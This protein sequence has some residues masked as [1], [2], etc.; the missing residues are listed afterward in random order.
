MKIV[1]IKKSINGEINKWHQGSPAVFIRFAGCNL[2]THPCKF[3]DTEYSLDSTAGKD[4]SIYELKDVLEQYN[5]EDVI[6]LTGGEPLFHV[7]SVMDV[8]NLVYR[9]KFRKVVIETNGTLSPKGV[10]D[11]FPEVNIVMDYKLMSSGNQHLMVTDNFLCLRS[12]DFIKFPVEN[13]FDMDMAISVKNILL[14]EISCK[15][16]I[17]PIFKDGLTWSSKELVKETRDNGFILSVQIHK[18][19]E[20]Y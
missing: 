9:M 2:R 8:L 19:L 4:Y 6:V 13:M 14:R 5:R 15:M 3:C 17:S 11:A 18:I 16:A 12:S 20:C 1:E 7:K 10:I